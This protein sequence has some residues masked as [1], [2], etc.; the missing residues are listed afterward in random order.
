[1]DNLSQ[2]PLVPAQ[3]GAK[4][5]PVQ[6]SVTQSRAQPTAKTA[7]QRQA[8]SR[9]KRYKAGAHGDG[10]RQL[11]TWLDTGAALALERVANRYS[12]TKSQLLER[13]IREEDARILETIDYNSKEWNDYFGLPTVT[14]SRSPETKT[15]RTHKGHEA[16][17]FAD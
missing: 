12:V 4:D 5:A 14:Q 6:P 7:A 2:N 16:T 13:L 1:M 8:E 9:A 15:P 10:Q 17:D 11:N 3:A